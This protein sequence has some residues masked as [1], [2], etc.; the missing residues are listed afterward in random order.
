MIIKSKVPREYDLEYIPDS[1]EEE[2]RHP[3]QNIAPKNGYLFS[4]SPNN[5]NWDNW[6]SPVSKYFTVGEV[7]Q[8]DTRRI[9]TETNIKFNILK[10]AQQL[11]NIR[12]SWGS[13]IGV[14]S[15]YRPPAVNAAV[16]GVPN[17]RHILGNAVDIYPIN[18]SIG[19]FQEWLDG[20]W[21]GNLGY[22]AKK[23]FVHID[24]GNNKGWMSGGSKGV[25]WNY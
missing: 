8:W 19:R 25:R 20:R 18:G 16:G 11:D 12:E 4:K 15:W 6:S 14:T 22:G 24:M 9:P 13:G 10:L 23:G 21:Y 5:I 2:P 17:S 7:C 3:Q 1:Q